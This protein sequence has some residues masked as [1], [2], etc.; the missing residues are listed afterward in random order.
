M[1]LS[2]NKKKFIVLTSMVLLLVVA[3]TL[4]FL[5]NSK[6]KDPAGGELETTFFAQ[7]RT[8]R[9]SSRAEQISLLDA[10]INSETSTAE[11]ITNAENE[12]LTLCKI[13]EKELVLE[14]LVKAQGFDDV[15]V[16]MGTTNC[17]IVVHKENMLATD[18]DV[19]YDIITR[20]TDYTSL[21]IVVTPVATEN[22]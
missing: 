6:L 12:K 15:I 20:E 19:I 10:I 11:A 13:M 2:A 5:L 4:N 22:L 21:N 8:L 1:K 18:A 14:S 16:T 3:G 7:H 17:N 9:E